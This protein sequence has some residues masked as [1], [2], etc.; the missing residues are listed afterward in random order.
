MEDCTRHAATGLWTLRFTPNKD[1]EAVNIKRVV[2]LGQIASQHLTNYLKSRPLGSLAEELGDRVFFRSTAS[3]S[4][5][6]DQT[7]IRAGYPSHFFSGH[8]GKVGSVMK[9]VC[10]QFLDHGKSLRDAAERVSEQVGWKVE[11]NIVTYLRNDLI[12]KLPQYMAEKK[13][14]KDLTVRELHPTAFKGQWSGPN[15]FRCRRLFSND[16]V[17][18]PLRV[19]TMD[20]LKALSESYRN[21]EDASMDM[22]KFGCSPLGQASFFLEIF[23]LLSSIHCICI[24]L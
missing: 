11:A 9:G 15:N 21:S 24:R 1:K 18:E 22:S 16:G 12:A 8:S 7:C 14:Y 2:E 17:S 20:L 23:S 13:L 4:R 6:L 10:T 5:N 3:F 19:V